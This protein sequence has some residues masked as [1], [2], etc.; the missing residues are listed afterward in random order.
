[1]CSAVY[2]HESNTQLRNFITF[3]ELKNIK[4]GKTNNLVIH[5][6]LELII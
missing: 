4:F 2:W 1:M 6:T 5:L 3:L